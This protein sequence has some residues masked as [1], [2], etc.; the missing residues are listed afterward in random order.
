M[1]TAAIRQ[2]ADFI[3][4]R[5]PGNFRMSCVIRNQDFANGGPCDSYETATVR[6]DA[7]LRELRESGCRTVGYIAGWSVILLGD[8]GHHSPLGRDIAARRRHPRP[9]RRT[10]RSPVLSGNDI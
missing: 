5:P 3:K 9:H 6:A 4:R 7:V 1:N 8:T 2:L 10:S